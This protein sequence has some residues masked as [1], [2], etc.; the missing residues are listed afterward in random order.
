MCFPQVASSERSRRGTWR[1]LYGPPIPTFHLCSSVETMTWATLPLRTQWSSI[2][3]PGVTTTSV[4]GWAECCAWCWTPS[5]S[6][7]HQAA[8][9]W[10]KLMR[11]GW[12]NSYRKQPRAQHGTSLSSSTFHSTWKH[13]T[14]RTTT[15][16][17]RESRERVWFT[18]SAK[19]VRLWA[20]SLGEIRTKSEHASSQCLLCLMLC[21]PIELNMLLSLNLWQSRTLVCRLITNCPYSN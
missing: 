18:D 12:R 3:V 15:S 9:S 6:L 19:Q 1:M 5:C 11:P 14:R 16:I 21:L 4:S 10:R 17:C 8:L 20:A 7:T 2:A 13:L